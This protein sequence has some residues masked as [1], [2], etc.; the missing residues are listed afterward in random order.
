MKRRRGIIFL[1]VFLVCGS[2][3]GG[4][5]VGKDAPE[6]KI[7][8]WI[9][10][11]PPEIK[12]LAGKVYVVEFW[13]TWCHPC[14]ENIP[15]LIELCNKFRGTGLEFIAISGDKSAETVR[16]F[17]SDKK[18]NYHVAIDNGSADGYG[19]KGYPTVFVV[20]HK[21]KVLWQGYP[22][23]SDFEKTIA[24]AVAAGPPPLLA[25]IELGRF[26]ALKKSLWGGSGFV[27]AYRQIQS[28]A[29]GNSDTKDRKLAQ[30]I[31][32]T[33]DRR[34]KEEANQAKHLQSKDPAMALAICADIVRRYDGIEAV[35]PAKAAY[36]ELKN[37][38]PLRSR[39]LAVK[40]TPASF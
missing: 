21:G 39:I 14:V 15:H 8:Q 12:D 6:I 24:K 1:L 16:E 35:K 28:L 40:K 29:A 33:I 5:L 36:L 10:D 11:N 4:S 31:I 26:S 38:K 23:E 37:H 19:I 2:C 22:W 18:I 17:I 9:T 30:K 25:G 7:R 20:N 34:I 3:I 32:E 27:R 13:T